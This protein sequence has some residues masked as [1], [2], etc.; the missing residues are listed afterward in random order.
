MRIMESKSNSGLITVCKD[1]RIG[2][3]ISHSG[4]QEEHKWWQEDFPIT[5]G[6]VTEGKSG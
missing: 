2:Q 6:A 4:N 5:V 1:K 3:S